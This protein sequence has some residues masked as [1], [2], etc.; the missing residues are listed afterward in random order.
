M[1]NAAITFVLRVRVAFAMADR[2]GIPASD[3]ALYAQ[4]LTALEAAE[5][6]L[7]RHQSKHP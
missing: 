7:H 3:P 6:A 2:V 4:K 5:A 1:R